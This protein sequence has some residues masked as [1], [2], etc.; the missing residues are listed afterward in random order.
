MVL[1]AVFQM[2]NA[3]KLGLKDL[4][5]RQTENASAGTDTSDRRE[6][7]GESLSVHCPHVTVHGYTSICSPTMNQN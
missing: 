3:D 7:R 4:R 5:A 6:S 1:G 2:E